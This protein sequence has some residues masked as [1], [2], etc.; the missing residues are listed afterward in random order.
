MCSRFYW[1]LQSA[2]ALKFV[3]T[4]HIFLLFRFSSTLG[5]GLMASYHIP[6]FPQYKTGCDLN[7]D[8][9]VL[10]NGS[11]VFLC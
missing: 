7:H 3:S 5:V 4:R 11:N 10:P 8:V 6:S 9:C 2:S 1:Q